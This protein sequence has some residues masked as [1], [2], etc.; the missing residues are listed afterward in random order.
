MDQKLSDLDEVLDFKPTD[1][2]YVVR[3]GVSFRVSG[4]LLQKPELSELRDLVTSGLSGGAPIK[5]DVAT[6]VAE[7]SADSYFSVP[8]QEEDSSLVIYK[9]VPSEPTGALEMARIASGSLLGVLA[10]ETRNYRALGDPLRSVPIPDMALILEDQNGY[11]ALGVSNDGTLFAKKVNVESLEVN[12]L[13]IGDAELMHIDSGP[14]FVLQD[15]L[16]RLAFSVDADGNVLNNSKRQASYTRF[17]VH[18]KALLNHSIVS[19]QSLSVGSNSIAVARPALS[20]AY[21]FSG[22]VRPGADCASLI[23]FRESTDGILGET[24]T[25]GALKM[26]RELLYAENGVPENF[27]GYQQIGS[28]PGEGATNI[29]G[30]QPGWPRYGR[31][32]NN[33]T[34]GYAR[35]Q[36]LNKTYRLASTQWFQGEADYSIGTTLDTFK[37]L[38]TNVVDGIS[39][40]AISV[41]GQQ[42]PIFIIPQIASHLRYFKNEGIAT[43]AECRMALA[44]A[45]L[46]NERSD[47]YL[48]CPMYI[49]DYASGGYGNPHLTAA[50]S[51]IAG[52]Y[53]GLVEKRVLIDGED[54]QPLQ[55]ISLIRDGA[56]VRVKFYVPVGPLVIDTD[57]V[58]ENENYGFNLFQPDGTTEIPI[59]QVR[60]SGVDS[61]DI[62]TGGT[63]PAGAILRYAF[64]TN[65]A[66][67]QC[68]RMVGARG[69]LRDS[70]GDTIVFNKRMVRHQMHNW[71]R[72]F[73]E[74]VS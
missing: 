25:W 52:A 22:G 64:Y 69:N 46:A 35:A 41:T 47:V 66:A 27:A 20:E 19:G 11:Y 65:V 38:T 44:Q 4:A 56:A 18:Q 67:G 14:S 29:A 12:A 31:M 43:A 72:L 39:A 21:M 5:D 74:T 59:T 33:I 70:Q 48:S 49:L 7:T 30:W 32:L 37:T 8:A 34:E 13:P 26:I 55:P 62:V 16:G 9:N 51:D 54:W 15:A 71:C 68:G 1:T 2:F 73:E 24:P 3:D 42:A 17:N 53:N 40:H 36:E 45:Q 60:L 57:Y 63:V 10:N 23:P 6:G 28:A 50:S 61:L 58:A